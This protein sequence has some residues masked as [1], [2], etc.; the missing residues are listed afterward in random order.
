MIPLLLPEKPYHRHRETETEWNFICLKRL[1][2][3]FIKI[4]GENSENWNSRK[5]PYEHTHT[6][7]NPESMKYAIALHI[8][9]A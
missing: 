3:L 8:A 5:A 6:N 2:N 1:A 7:S 9:C 4:A